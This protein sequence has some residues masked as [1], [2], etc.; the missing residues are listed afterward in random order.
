M[1]ELAERIAAWGRRLFGY[2]GRVVRARSAESEYLVDNPGRR[3][4]VI[5]KARRELGYRPEV[6]LDEGLRRSLVWYAHNRE[7]AEA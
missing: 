2:R 7:A 3:C 6:D 5:E 1:F 4:P